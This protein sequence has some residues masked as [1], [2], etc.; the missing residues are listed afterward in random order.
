MNNI[1]TL[2][3]DTRFLPSDRRLLTETIV[4]VNIN[5]KRS[6]QQIFQTY[7]LKFALV[8]DLNIKI[9]RTRASSS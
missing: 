2:S 3:V 5:G 7:S 6:A 8:M 4:D 9:L 1:S